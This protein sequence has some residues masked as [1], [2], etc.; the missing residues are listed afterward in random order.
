MLLFINSSTAGK[1]NVIISI[2]DK[3][4]SSSFV[5]AHFIN[6]FEINWEGLNISIPAIF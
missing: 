3:K 4:K 5:S 6:K 1:G 2:A